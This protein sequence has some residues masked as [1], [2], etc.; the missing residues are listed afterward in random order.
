MEFILPIFSLA[1]LLFFYF[2]EEDVNKR[3]LSLIGVVIGVLHAMLPM[4]FINEKIF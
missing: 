2:I 3:I 4:Q 1:N